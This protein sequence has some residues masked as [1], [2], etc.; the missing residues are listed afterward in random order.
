[1]AI[2]RIG[3]VVNDGKS[4]ALEAAGIVRA[5]GREHNVPCTDVDVWE[6]LDGSAGMIDRQKAACAG[7][8]DLIVTIGGDGTLL[9][10]VR[11]AASVDALVLGVNLGRVGFLTE[12]GV[13][14][15]H[16]ALDAV[17][18]GL[19]KLTNGSP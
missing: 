8:P 7:V 19:P 1:M 14:D 9:R 12:V 6:D 3:L 13:A 16:D 5:W 11:V 2:R 4:E 15:L 10:G 17:H 18:A